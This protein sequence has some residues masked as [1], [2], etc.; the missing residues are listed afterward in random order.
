MAD[1]LH[2]LITISTTIG[3]VS[4]LACCADDPE[5]ELLAMLTKCKQAG[6]VVVWFEVR[7]V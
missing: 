5:W 7:S 6:L 3:F 4:H 1:R 2:T